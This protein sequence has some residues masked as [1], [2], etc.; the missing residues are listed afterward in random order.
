M[1]LFV[2]PITDD[3][4]APEPFVVSLD[5]AQQTLLD[6]PEF[7]GFMNRML[8]AKRPG[9]LMDAHYAYLRRCNHYFQI[10]SV[11]DLRDDDVVFLSC[12]DGLLPKGSPLPERRTSVSSISFMSLSEGKDGTMTPEIEKEE[13]LRPRKVR[14][15][16]IPSDY[17]CDF[18]IDSHGTS[19]PK[20]RL[21]LPRCRTT[22]EKL[23]LHGKK[24]NPSAEI[25]MCSLFRTDTTYPG[26]H[27]PYSTW[28]DGE[29]LF[30]EFRRN[31]LF[32]HEHPK[33]SDALRFVL[34]KE[35]GVHG[36]SSGS[37]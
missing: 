36:S 26:R 3:D 4:C 11:G 24:Y 23:I 34:E 37:S 14:K 18:E 25:D 15:L 22:M 31:P 17:R 12:D 28:W 2:V 27:V 30:N 19:T 16:S 5:K 35:P 8:V 1:R 13:T 10:E 9:H 7:L 21:R 33:V 20:R 6:V 29:R 32:P